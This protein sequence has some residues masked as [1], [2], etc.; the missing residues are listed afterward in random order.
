MLKKM[1]LVYVGGQGCI[2][3]K[4]WPTNHLL[5]TIRILG[6]STNGSFSSSCP[7]RPPTDGARAVDPSDS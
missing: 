7:E 3:E 2:R 4:E 5:M 1:G 6:K